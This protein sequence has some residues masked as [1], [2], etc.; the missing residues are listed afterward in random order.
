MEPAVIALA[1]SC[2]ESLPIIDMV[3]LLG[4]AIGTPKD[5]TIKHSSTFED[6]DGALILSEA[7][8]P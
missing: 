1:P 5:L 7:L 4:D 6:N 8:S 2:R 3:A